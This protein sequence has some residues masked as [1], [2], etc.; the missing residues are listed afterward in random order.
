MRGRLRVYLCMFIFLGMAAHVEAKQLIGWVENVRVSPGDVTVKAKI[1]TGA[2]TSSLDCECITPFMRDGK[3]WLSFSVKNHQG[4]IV[5]LEKPVVRI[6]RI[7]RHFGQQQRR[8]VVKLGICLGTVYREAEV[9]LIDRSGFNY[10]LLVG[11]NF[12]K[13][14]F[15]I[16]PSRTFTRHPRCKAGTD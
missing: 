9:T 6:A 10:S 1:D 4:Q 8:Y 16:D 2:K 12:L 15:L 11:R 3:Q 5:Q 13:D 14:D 7:R